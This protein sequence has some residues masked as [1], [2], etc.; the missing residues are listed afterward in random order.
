M[1]D[2]NDLKSMGVVAERVCAA[3]PAL[4]HLHRCMAELER[5]EEPQ[6]GDH[7]G[8]LHRLTSDTVRAEN[9]VQLLRHALWAA[10]H[11]A[12]AFGD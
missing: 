1:I 3:T 12:E 8:T 5:W 2:G 11:C 10:Q 7:S 9:D 6:G 4:D